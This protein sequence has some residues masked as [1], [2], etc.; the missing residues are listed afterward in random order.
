MSLI[1]ALFLKDILDFQIG[2]IPI[3][4]GQGKEV[5]A[6]ITTAMKSNKTFYT[7]SSGRDFIERV[8]VIC[9]C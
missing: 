1:G 6:E 5:V 3:D 2:P 9:L 8:Y 7:D 4:D